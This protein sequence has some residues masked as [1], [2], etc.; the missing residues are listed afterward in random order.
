[1][2]SS[3]V[4]I[5]L[6]RLAH[7]H[8]QHPNLAQAKEF[9]LDFGLDV[10]EEN[11]QKIFARGHGIDPI[12]PCFYMGN[13]SIRRVDISPKANTTQAKTKNDRAS[14]IDSSMGR[15]RSIH[16]LSHFGFMVPSSKFLS[17]RTWYLNTSNLLI[18]DSVFDSETDND[19]TSFIHID[20]GTRTPTT[21]FDPSG[22]IVEHYTDGDLINCDTAVHRE[23]VAKHSLYVWVAN[24]PRSFPVGKC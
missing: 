3:R 17:N 24:S 11:E 8:Y 20:L 22:F 12:L 9:L 16:K 10:V 21:M 15:A 13:K 7:V 18:M 23:Q 6:L 19:V 1:M 5:Q 14:F 4:K 2:A